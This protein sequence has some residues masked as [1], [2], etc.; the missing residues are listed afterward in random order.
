M[1]SGFVSMRT[2]LYGGEVPVIRD[3]VPSLLGMPVARDAKDLADVDVAIIGIPQGA[4]ASPGRLPS[5]WSDYGKAIDQMRH[6]S[7]RY[8]GYVPE[9]DVD[10]FEHL[11][12][13]DCGNA[14][15]PP[16]DQDRAIANVARMVGE[17]L[18]AGCRVITVGGC[19]PTANYGVARGVASATKGKVGTISF[20]AH[21]DCLDYLSVAAGRTKPGPGT[22][23]R[24]LWEHCQN[25]DPSCHVEIG[26][27]GPRNVR[28]MVET[29]KRNGARLY[30]AATVRK[31]GIDTLCASAFPHAFNGVERTWFSLCLDVLDIGA[32]PDWG[33]EPLGLSSHDVVEG[34]YQAATM[35]LDVLA[36]HF[37]APDSPCAQ[38]LA[39]YIC[40]YTMA[41][42]IAHDRG[43]R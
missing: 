4:Q 12:V 35:G 20:D 26:M 17:A 6:Q 22:W 39:C 29:Y 34:A 36:I 28:E 19:V 1:V 25:V 37:V 40:V 2:A 5:E 15:I 32:I 42:W 9:Y 8:G 43:E 23:Q 27:R 16:D 13:V 33:D 7:L 21:G 11:K 30:P 3:G 41:G 38:R 24:R 10:V 14:E 31:W 18:E